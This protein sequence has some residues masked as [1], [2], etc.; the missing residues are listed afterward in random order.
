[1]YRAGVVVGRGRVDVGERVERDGR[2]QGRMGG[3]LF[4]L[5]L[6]PYLL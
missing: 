2:G 6:S 1:M 5:P 3:G 4:P